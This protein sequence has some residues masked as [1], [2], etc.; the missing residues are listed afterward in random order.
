MAKAP[1]KPEEKIPEAAEGEAPAPKKKRGKLPL[2]IGLVVILAAGGGGAFYFLR[3][4][5]SGGEKAAE[6]VEVKHEPLKPPVFVQLENFTVNLASESGE[7]Y[8]QVAATL[9]VLDAHTGDAAKLYM[10]EIRHRILLWLAAKKPKEISTPVGRERLAE[11]LRVITNNILLTAA[12]KPQRPMLA[13]AE[14][15]AE[16]APAEKA[17]KAE[18]TDNP[19]NADKPK[20]ESPKAETPKAETPATTAPTT[21]PAQSAEGSLVVTA[22]TDD[23][24]QSVLFTSFIIQ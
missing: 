14:A 2:I 11:E 16:E 10:P 3:G 8:L 9:K 20:E 5:S 13:A 12:G 23:P 19:E 6:V 15:K 22:A 17:E 21:V 18:K 24:V 7:Q 1:A 4:G